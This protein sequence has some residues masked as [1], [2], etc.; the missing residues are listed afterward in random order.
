MIKYKFNYGSLII[1]GNIVK[2]GIDSS[3]F[4]NIIVCYDSPK[5]FRLG[6]F[7]F[8]P[9]LFH[10]HEISIKETYA[11][12]IN[13]FDF[14]KEKARKSIDDW[15][16]G[17]N[18]SI[19]RDSPKSQKYEDLVENTNKEIISKKGEN[20]K[21]GYSDIKII[22]GF[23][24]EGVTIVHVR[25]KGFEETCKILNINVINPTWKEINLENKKR[26]D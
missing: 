24:S 4:I 26:K 1:K 20:Y 21:I 19:I 5:D 14:N 25:D 13:E 17:L 12:L 15:S 16:K 6:D 10:L 3:R 2:N 9:N 11:I 8:P 22:S 18:L 7:P 23:L